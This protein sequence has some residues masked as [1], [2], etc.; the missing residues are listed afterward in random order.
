MG[1][2][3]D[4]ESSKK[5][6]SLVEMYGLNLRFAEK[7]GKVYKAYTDKGEF[8]LK[9][10]DAKQGLDF[11]SYIQQLYQQGYNRIVPIYP[12]LDGRHAI[13]RGNSL[14]Y[15]MPWLDNKEREAHVQKHLDLFRE[16]ARLH[17]VTVREV[18]V[19]GEEREE[20]FERMATRWELEQ[21]V[22]EKFI[23]QSERQLYMSPFQLLLCTI[24]SEIS[25]GQRYAINKLKEWHESTS[26]ETKARSVVIHGKLS[27][28]HFLYDQNGLGYFTNFERTGIASPIHDLLPFLDR[29]FQT[30]PQ[31]FDH[32]MEWLDAY[33]R[34]FPFTDE[35]MQL[36]LSYLAYPSSIFSIIE[37]YFSS[38]TTKNEIKFVQRLQKQYWRMKNTEYVVMRLEEREQRKK[39]QDTSAPSE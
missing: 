34:Y 39:N 5:I 30:R 4:N 19:N 27:N 3:M 1:D 35:E 20:H 2:D 25:G 37:K 14:Y 10:M 12:T 26:E 9:R 16:L 8:A 13:L 11:L 38:E 24:Y 33:F 7:Q 23:E 31:A 29:A 32:G 6:K 28:E 17:T 18:P 15:L 21:D 22:L 36:F